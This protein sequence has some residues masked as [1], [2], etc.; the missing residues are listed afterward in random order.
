MSTTTPTPTEGHEEVLRPVGVRLTGVDLRRPDDALVRRLVHLLAEHGVVVMPDQH[1]DDDAFEAFLRRF[2][3]PFFTTGETPVEGHPD[4][5]VISN[6]GRTSP[7]RST[8]HVDSSYVASPPAYTALRTVQVPAQGGQTLFSNQYEALRT[9]PPEVRDDLEGRNIRHVVTGV[10][11]GPDDE[12]ESWHPA[13]RRHPVSG[14][15]ALYLSTPA[16]CVEVSGMS[17]AESGELVA[18]LHEHSTQ[19]RHV[20]RHAWVEGDVVMW[21]NG[22][23]MHQA[24]HS[25]V[26]GDRVMHRGMALGYAAGVPGTQRETA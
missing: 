5:N 16:R 14:R 18:M 1:L 7:P 2:G 9:L 23:V 3:A 13:V 15:D 22:C 11:L 4:L 17:E 26:V 25:G 20:L 12:H 21:D 8:F 24:D 6:V 10:D 19:E